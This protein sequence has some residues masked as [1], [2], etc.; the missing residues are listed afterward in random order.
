L[1]PRLLESEESRSRGPKGRRRIGFEIEDT[2]IGI[3]SDQI[4]KLFRPFERL[5]AREGDVEGTGLGLSISHQ[6]VE[7][8]GGKLSV[9]S[10][11]G[12]GSVFGF[13]LDLPLGDEVEDQD[14]SRRIIGYGGRRI[15]VLVADDKHANRSLIANILRPLGFECACVADGAEAV[16][17]AKRLKPDMVLLDIVMPIKSGL[18]AAREIHGIPG[19]QGTFIVASSASVFEETQKKCADSGCDFFLPKPV[20][21]K[22]LLGCI[23]QNLC[24][25]WIYE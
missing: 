10:E 20:S 15:R 12:K 25:K 18:E 17:V 9:R 22:E 24:L 21:V 6:L 2:G 11:P 23:G 16:E 4:R 8:M 19:L 14:S 7:L 5:V 1:G 13:E 3:A